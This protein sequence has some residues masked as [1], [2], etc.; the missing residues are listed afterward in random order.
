MPVTVTVSCRPEPANCHTGTSVITLSIDSHVALPLMPQVL[1]GGAPRFDL[2]A[3]HTVPI[4]Q[5]VE[6]GAR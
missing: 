3:S 1:G 6:A 5:Y 4:G 2:D